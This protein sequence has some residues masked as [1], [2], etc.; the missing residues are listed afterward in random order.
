MGTPR[1]FE[2]VLG[3]LR[4]LLRFSL[5]CCTHTGRTHSTSAFFLPHTRRIRRLCDR[6]PTRKTVAAF[7]PA[8]LRV[9]TCACIHDTCA[10]TPSST[11][12]LRRQLT[13]KDTIQLA[14][15][16]RSTRFQAMS[17]A[18]VDTNGDQKLSFEEF[19]CMLPRQLV[20]RFSTDLI[21]EWFDQADD[22]GSGYLS[23][24]EFFKWSIQNVCG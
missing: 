13:R 4:H 24:D 11:R 5:F 10:M 21:R 9:D 22:D 23:I 14:E 17:F 19:Y 1:I 16:S 6:P 20:D 7:S 2:L 8:R 3:C 12:P 15:V 18:E